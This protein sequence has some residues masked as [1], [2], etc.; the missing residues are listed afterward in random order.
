MLDNNIKPVKR[1][2]GIIL[3]KVADN[4]TEIAFEIRSY[5]A[6]IDNLLESNKKINISL[7]QQEDKNS[8]L[9]RTIQDLKDQMEQASI[10]N[11]M[12]IS[13]LKDQHL[14]EIQQLEI[15]FGEREGQFEDEKQKLHK[16]IISLES[17]IR[18]KSNS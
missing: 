15:N 2:D 5:S 16:Y 6:T 12:Q 10:Q 1:V 4:I 8:E 11:E 14:K 13:K 3:G 18:G 7:K 17:R 9:H